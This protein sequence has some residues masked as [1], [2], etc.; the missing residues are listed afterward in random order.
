MTAPQP[1]AI[2]TPVSSSRVATHGTPVPPPRA[3]PNTSSVEPSAPTS[4][5][6]P[7]HGA[8]PSSIV[9]SA[10][11]AAPPDTPST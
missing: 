6:V 1:A 10:A 8:N 4:A 9:A 2:T 7:D 3:R 5:A 11:A